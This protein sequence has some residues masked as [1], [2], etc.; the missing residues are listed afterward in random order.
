MA[1]EDTEGTETTPRCL[2]CLRWP[3]GVSAGGLVGTERTQRSSARGQRVAKVDRLDEVARKSPGLGISLA[4]HGVLF[5]ALPLIV[6]THKRYLPDDCVWIGGGIKSAP[7]R[8]EPSYSRVRLGWR[9]DDV[10]GA[11]T[12]DELGP[13]VLPRLGVGSEPVPRCPALLRANVASSARVPA[14][15][16]KDL[17]RLAELQSP[18]GV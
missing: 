13:F 15:T 7:P 16:V 9:D 8:V 14:E 10:D 17:F 6:F 2:R 1:T 11:P 3:W 4:F 18:D 5:A 12:P